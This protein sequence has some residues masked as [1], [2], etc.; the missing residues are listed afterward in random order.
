MNCKAD[1]EKFGERDYRSMCSCN[2]K[3]GDVSCSSEVVAEECDS[4]YNKAVCD[5]S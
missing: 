5:K 2:N 4:K 1:C 3:D